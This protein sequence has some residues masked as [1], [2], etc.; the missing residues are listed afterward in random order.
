M[1]IACCPDIYRG[2]ES[3]LCKSLFY[4]PSWV[5]KSGKLVVSDLMNGPKEIHFPGSWFGED[6][7]RGNFIESEFTQVNGWTNSNEEEGPWAR[8]GLFAS[9]I[10][11]PSNETVNIRVMVNFPNVSSQL[12]L[13]I[14]A[15]EWI[16]M[17]NVS[18]SD[19]ECKYIHEVIWR[20]LPAKAN[21]D[22]RQATVHSVRFDFPP[23]NQTVF[24]FQRTAMNQYT[25]YNNGNKINFSVPCKSTWGF[26]LCINGGINIFRHS[27][28]LKPSLFHCGKVRI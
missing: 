18:G 7:E 28:A 14:N 17:E 5:V 6:L 27:R 13:T 23:P 25:T 11:I 4:D 19:E 16:E 20:L 8:Q 24:K 26:L 21:L 12:V 9:G 15:I 10:Y 2:V 22:E 1:E 3:L